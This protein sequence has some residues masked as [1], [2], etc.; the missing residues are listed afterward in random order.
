MH[1][2]LS[3]LILIVIVTLS[4]CSKEGGDIDLVILVEK[5]SIKSDITLEVGD[6]ETLTVEFTPEKVTNKAVTWSVFPKD[7]VTV[8]ADGRVTAVNVGSATI[9]VSSVADNTKQAICEVKV[10]SRSLAIGDYY[11]SD[12]SYSL[13]YN[14]DKTCIGIVFWIDP[15]N[16][17]KGKIVSLNDRQRAWG[18]YLNEDIGGM[19]GYENFKDEWPGDIN[20]IARKDGIQNRKLLNR[21]IVEN[22]RSLGDYP[23]FEWCSSEE[24]EE[25]DWYLPSLN[26]LQYLW[27]AYNGADPV[28]WQHHTVLPCP[29]VNLVAQR[30]F[31]DKLTT[32]PNGMKI[33]NLGYWSSTESDANYGWMV[34]FVDGETQGGIKAFENN[35]ARAVAVFRLQ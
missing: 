13:N 8:N 31:N 15:A 11:Y 16:S 7:I 9:T 25:V 34:V 18:H 19:A 17:T 24:V 5:L 30:S 1:N 28:I 26:E 32:V 12:N 29:A 21:Y 35:R 27:C 20:S 3:I 6:A 23:A 22:K 33:S 14:S 4:S 10:T 2:K